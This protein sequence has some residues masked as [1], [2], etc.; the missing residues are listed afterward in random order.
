MKKYL[1]KNFAGLD[2]IPRVSFDKILLCT[3][4]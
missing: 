2:N 4:N 1:D 3:F